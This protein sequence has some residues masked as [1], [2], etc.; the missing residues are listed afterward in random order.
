L[1]Q[2]KRKIT[3]ETLQENKAFKRLC[4][5]HKTKAEDIIETA[6][7]V[8]DLEDMTLQDQ[9]V[10]LVRTL[11]IAM[12]KEYSTLIGEYFDTIHRE[13]QPVEKITL[14]MFKEC[15]EIREGSPGHPEFNQWSGSIKIQGRYRL[16]IQAGEYVYSSPRMFCASPDDYSAF[17]IALLD[18]ETRKFVRMGSFV[19]G[20][21]DYEQVLGWKSVDEILEIANTFIGKLNDGWEVQYA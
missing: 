5:K 6:T 16:S 19:N 15:F 7:S 18:D 2:N 3:M 9:E 8:F 11:A 20:V 13:G 17:E 1:E 12:G 4:R 21:E 10:T 14:Q